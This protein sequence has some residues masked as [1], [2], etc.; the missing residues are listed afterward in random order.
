MN[1]VVQR[2]GALPDWAQGQDDR[3][4]FEAAW[5]RVALPRTTWRASRTR[6]DA[7]LK[8][9]AVPAVCNTQLWRRR[10]DIEHEANN[11]LAMARRAVPVAPLLAWGQHSLGPV[12]RRS[13]L[14]AELLPRAESLR[15]LIE[16]RLAEGRAD[17][18]RQPLA[19]AG[20]A[21]AALHAEGWVHDDLAARNV[22]IFHA[23]GAPAAR[24]VDVARAHCPS[25]PSARARGR[26]IDLYRLAKAGY[27]YGLSPDPVA[28]M[29]EAAAPGQGTA[30]AEVTRS[31]RAISNRY[32][33][34]A[35]YHIWTRFGR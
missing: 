18:L 13:W 8:G 32:A 22:V 29:I 19:L 12:P 20:G 6:E 35:R 34:M 28:H 21:V 14:L 4:L 2:H 27:R 3:A 30:I 17:E 23:A 25:D 11:Q 16:R 9:M 10:W 31:I 1:L 5:S 26:R 15:A 7:F 24:I 33:R